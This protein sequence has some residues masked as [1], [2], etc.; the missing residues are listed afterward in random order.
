MF[1]FHITPLSLGYK[2]VQFIINT[3]LIILDTGKYHL[4]D[5]AIFML[6]PVALR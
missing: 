4:S 2:I 3:L 1:I 5:L 6:L